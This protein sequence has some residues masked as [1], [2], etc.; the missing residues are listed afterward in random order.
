VRD[1]AEGFPPE[2]TWKHAPADGE[3]WADWFQ[4]GVDEAVAVLGAVA[5]SEHRWTWFAPDQTAGWYHVRTPQETSVHRIDAELAATG[6]ADP[7]DP[8]FAV[9]GVD[10]L[11][12]VMVPSADETDLG[13]NGETILV[14]AT[15]ADAAWVVTL[16]PR[17]VSVVKARCETTATVRGSATDLLLWV[18]GRPPLG[19]L[20]YA[21]DA[22]PID[23][24]SAAFRE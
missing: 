22:S 24:L 17:T 19:A 8:A 4:A 21:G 2:E 5:P 9:E 13:G 14:E 1:R 11:F 23:R 6:S 15:D 18:W 20:D 12:F 10:E 7:V 3:S 16:E